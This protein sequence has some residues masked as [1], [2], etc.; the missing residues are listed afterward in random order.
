MSAPPAPDRSALAIATLAAGGLLLPSGGP[1]G[2]GLALLGS[3][4]LLGLLGVAGAPPL[5]A[6]KHPWIEALATALLLTLLVRAL[7]QLLVDIPAL[8]LAL[9]LALL[10]VVALARVGPR[11]RLL[12]S[13]GLLAL[14]IAAAWLGLALEQAGPQPRG[15]ARSSPILGVHPRQAVAITIDGYGPHDVIAD[16]FVEPSGGPGHD[17]ASWATRLESELHRIAALHYAEGPARA[18]EAFGQAEVVVADPAI[19][20]EDT[21]R[22]DPVG[23]EIRSGTVGEGSRVELGCP[24][25]VGDP[26][27]ASQRGEVRL[28]ACPRKYARDGSTGLGLSPRWAGYTEL[29]GRDR[30][31]LAR[32]LGWPSGDATRDRRLLALELGLLALG[33]LA[34]LLLLA[35][36]A[37]G[38][39]DGGCSREPAL[40]AGLALVGLA[41]V[42]A[43]GPNPPSEPSALLLL[44]PLLIV[45]GRAPGRGIGL[46]LALAL[47][48]AFAVL[49]LSP[50]G[51]RVGVVALAQ[52]LVEPLV[53][54]LG[55]SWAI[56]R[57]IAGA[58]LCLALV[59]GAL[60]CAAR[61]VGPLTAGAPARPL[62]PACLALA[63][64]LGL[65]LR[66]PGDDPALLACATALL[67]AA[68]L[69]RPGPRGRLAALGLALAA[70]LPLLDPGSRDFV[71][72]GLLGGLALVT[73]LAGW[74]SAHR[75]VEP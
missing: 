42:P 28:A 35:R 59:P 66:K 63:L 51:Q 54:D 43:T 44:A 75:R 5:R 72:L 62:G 12:A 36:A 52:G 38:R 34:A 13:P 65:A 53:L 33:L 15:L 58:I 57:V 29:R 41:L 27:P 70:A 7:A 21:A 49:G 20:P 25:Q 2:L 69:D 60:A 16:D 23:L 17:A 30:V 6:A 40:I 18:R 48:L 14:L 32:A 55:A 68:T 71:A 19:A 73:L 64:S 1:L 56:A 24:G 61:L 47:V 26:R 8:A 4:G 74:S 45:A 46:A 50:L 37:P 11:V 3:L 67:L 22:L 31:R 10:G 39:L 9:P